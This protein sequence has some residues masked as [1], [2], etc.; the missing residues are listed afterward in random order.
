MS[1]TSMNV[2]HELA[3]QTHPKT[4]KPVRYISEELEDVVATNKEAINAR[5]NYER[6]FLFDYFGFKID[7]LD[8]LANNA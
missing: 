2:I 5:V 6:D 4:G 8:K 3:H 7:D 1:N